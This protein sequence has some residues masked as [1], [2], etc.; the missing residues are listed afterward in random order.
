VIIHAAARTPVSADAGTTAYVRSNALGSVGVAEFARRSHATYVIYLSS[1]SV[2]GEVEE[3]V[4]T[5][6]TPFRRP[7]AYG[8]SKYMGEVALAEKTPSDRLLVL[9]LPGVLVPDNYTPWPG[10][11]LRLAAEGR[12]IEV[13]NPGALFNNVTDVDDLTRFIRTA[14]NSAQRPAGTFL[15][16]SSAPVPVRRVA[17][18][19][20]DLSGS[21]SK[22]REIHSPR[23]S[24]TIAVDKLR[25]D[26]GFIPS[27]TEDIISRYV[28]SSR[29]GPAGR[30]VVERPRMARAPK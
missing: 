20:R 17:G 14:V 22:I 2:Y 4:L 7:D 6:E 18:L 11:V 9:R 23:H 15:V 19:L 21:T 27:S 26:A 8:A 28:R 16:G 5:E 12:P 30:Q 25:A 10:R 13:Y 24:F 1:T 3:D 29:R